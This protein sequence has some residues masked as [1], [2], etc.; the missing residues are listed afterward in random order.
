MTFPQ[1]I[2]LTN[3]EEKCRS[4]L[5]E[6]E[7]FFAGLINKRGKLVAGG[8]KA[9]T[10][11][12]EDDAERQKLYMEYILMASMR[13]EFDYYFGSERYTVTKSKEMS[14]ISFPID[15]FLFLI[16]TDPKED[17]EK[18]AHKIEKILGITLGFS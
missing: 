7:I 17:I 6:K 16:T 5:K 10:R 9:D 18:E 2:N 3:L 11:P 4:I 12:I 8:F 15:S 1:T 14:M 13:K